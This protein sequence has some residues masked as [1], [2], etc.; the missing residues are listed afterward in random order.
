MNSITVPRIPCEAIGGIAKLVDEKTKASITINVEYN[1]LEPLLKN[2][3]LKGDV[4]DASGFSPYPGNI[5]I[6]VFH[7]ESMSTRLN[8]T[9]GIIDEFVNPKW[10][11][12]EKTKFKSP[13]R[14]ECMMQ[15]FPKLCKPDDKLG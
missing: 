10:A 14:L 6:L 2:T 3:A 5:N 15:D 13:T 9:E 4:A 7:I 1:E 11:D 8:E 12:A